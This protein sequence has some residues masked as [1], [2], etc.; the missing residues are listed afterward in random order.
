MIKDIVNTLKNVNF[1]IFKTFVVSTLRKEY[2]ELD[3]LDRINTERFV[4]TGKVIAKDAKEPQNVDTCTKII[5]LPITIK[6]LKK[7]PTWS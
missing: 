7:K 3:T 1:S 4:N 5:H 2:V 6:W